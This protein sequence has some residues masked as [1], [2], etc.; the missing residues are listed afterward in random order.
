M[1]GPII[2]TAM[3]LG[4]SG[5]AAADEPSI[6][7]NRPGKSTPTCTVPARHFQVETGV[8]D[9]SLQ[10]DGGTRDTS[11]ALGETTFIYGLSET[12]DIEVDVTPWQRDVSRGPGFRERNSGFGDVVALYKQR[13]TGSAAAVQI[14]ALPFVK[15][16]TAKRPLGNGKVE[17]GLLV[18]IDYSIP[19]S[20]ISI[21]ATPEID[22]VADADGHGRH[23]AMAQVVSLGIQATS[24]LGLSA[25]LWGQWDWDP[26]GT[27]RQVSA[28]GTLAYL[29][30]ERLQLDAGANFGLN[31]QTPD[32]ELYTGVSVRF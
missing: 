12:S 19:K 21:E 13:L 5:A 30:S 20:P 17:A 23:L 16:P 31:R 4:C 1:R 2:L 28:D 32:V 29:V 14:A 3:L 9:W 6:C 15:L 26:Q 27:T 8:A 18:P 22:W 10:Q 7:A 24:R 11:L 25:E